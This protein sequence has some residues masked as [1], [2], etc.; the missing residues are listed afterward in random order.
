MVLF[1]RDQKINRVLSEVRLQSVVAALITLRAHLLAVV[2]RARAR[3]VA[4][5]SRPCLFALPQRKVLLSA[6][7]LICGW[8]FD[9]GAAHVLGLRQDLLVSEW[10]GLDLLMG[11]ELLDL[12]SHVV[13]SSRRRELSVLRKIVVLVDARD[14]LCASLDCSLN[15]RGMVLDTETVV[16]GVVMV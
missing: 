8:R 14:L 12:G 5:G 13:W 4:R 11:D 1:L 15:I 2:G 3:L 7:P 10:L 9:L 6:G 16:R